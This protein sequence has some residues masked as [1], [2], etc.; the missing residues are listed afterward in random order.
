MY[1]SKQ[2]LDESKGNK[3]EYLEDWMGIDLAGQIY[4]IR[5]GFG[6][7]TE[8]RRPEAAVPSEQRKEKR[9]ERK[10]S[11]WGGRGRHT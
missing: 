2:I 9:G 8:E 5:G 6:R 11:G 1:K 7:G 4:R 3:G 10:G